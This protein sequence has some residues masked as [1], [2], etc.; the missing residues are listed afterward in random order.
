MEQ[1]NF[2]ERFDRLEKK[3]SEGFARTDE[4]FAQVTSRMEE[5]FAHVNRLIPLPELIESAV[6]VSWCR[7]FEGLM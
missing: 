4:R 5:G 1:P 6:A 3:V 2:E 7:I